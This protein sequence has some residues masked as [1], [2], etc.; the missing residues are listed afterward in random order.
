MTG[1]PGESRD[2][3]TG[4]TSGS[5]SL[6]GRLLV[7]AP[8]LSDPNF[9][10]TVVLMLEHGDEGGLG[11]VLNRPST[12]EVRGPLPDWESMATPPQVV[13]VGGPVSQGAVIALA[14]VETERRT[15]A[16]SRVL[17]RI[18]VLDLNTDPAE[19][20]VDVEEVRI[21]TGYAGWGAG[22]LEGEIREGAWFVVDALPA[23]ALATDPDLLWPEV[24]RR[25]GGAL[26]R[27]A[28]Y[29]PDP[30]VN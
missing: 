10:R 25:Q 14:R 17:P 23:D 2:A 30:S 29:P 15:E 27:L 22:Q 6:S 16:W 20:G 19:A 3:A 4:G 28:L 12:I 11:L 26:G 18:G 8:M 13:F 9:D 24:L 1:V 21:F 7:A 5:S